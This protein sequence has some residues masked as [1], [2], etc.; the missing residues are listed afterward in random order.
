MVTAE[1][2]VVLNLYREMAPGV[3][4]HLLQRNLGVKT[5]DGIYTPR[6]LMWMMMMQRLDARGTLASAVEQLAQNRFDGLLSRCKR[7]REN[8]IGL[9]TG[10]Y[11]QARQN[12]PKLLME[13]VVEEIVQ[14]LRNHLSKRIALL[15]RPVYVVD[16]S[17]LQLDH[18]GELKKAYPP[19]PSRRGESHWPIVRLVVLQDVE[20]GLAQQ[21]CWGPMF[22]PKAV[23]E[24]ALAERTMDPVPPGAVVIGD[25]NFGTFSI[26]YAIGQKGHAPVIRLTDVRAQKLKGGPIVAEGNY[27]VEWKASRWDKTKHEELPEDAAIGG[28]LIAWRMGRGKSK[29]WLY[30]FTTLILPAKQI[31]A[32]YGKRWNVETDLRSLKQTVRLQHLSVQSVDVMEKELLAAVLAYNLVRAIMCLA[33]RTA[34]LDPRQL[35]FTYAYNIV[36]DGI[37]SVLAASGNSEQIERLERIVSLVSRCRLPNRKKRRSF[38]REVWGHGQTFPSRGRNTK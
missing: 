33:A 30:L 16:G 35:S 28:R 3:L 32:L 26:A 36:Q 8:R 10:G 25:R 5:R 29:Q 27:P 34:G 11:C 9:S 7:V 20:T 1:L 24:Q 15:D 18:N 23:S 31:V 38:P 2:P 14:R 37:G 13:R 21:P 6:V 22:G 19:A 4:F 12:L 17:S